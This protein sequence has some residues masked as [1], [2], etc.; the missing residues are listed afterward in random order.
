M[1]RALGPD[2]GDVMHPATMQAIAAEVIRDKQDRSAAIRRAREARE[3][4][5][6]RVE[7]RPWPGL[8]PGLR[9][10]LRLAVFRRHQQATASR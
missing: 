3:T 9:A 8:R 7:R 5:G 4:M 10:G 6:D 1:A 2:Q